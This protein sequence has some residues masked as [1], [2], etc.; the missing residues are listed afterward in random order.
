MGYG[1]THVPASH[2]KL[3]L[4]WR[5]LDGCHLDDDLE[6]RVSEFLRKPLFGCSCIIYI[7]EARFRNDGL[8]E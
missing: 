3:G 2:R 5:K 4:L 7:F 8:A 6:A 1:K